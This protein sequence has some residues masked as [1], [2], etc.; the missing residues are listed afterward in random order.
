M[1]RLL[2]WIGIINASIWL[3]AGVFL[4]FCAG[5]ALF[6]PVVID[7]ITREKAGAVAQVVLAQYFKLQY[8]CA[9]IG[10]VHL[11]LSRKSMKSG[12][13][14]KISVVLLG[15]AL[16]GGLWLQPKLHRLNKTRYEA[17]AES[18]RGEASAEFKKWHGVSQM[19]NLAL[20]AGVL[21]QLSVLSRPSSGAG[22][23]KP[24]PPKPK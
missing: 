11:L 6:S 17:V 19:M 3:G 9:A 18:A 16:A 2:R 20:L 4:T 1:S 24:S 12:I 22:P 10:L 14:L 5:P 13:P 7:A 23:T 15:L 21:V 8:L